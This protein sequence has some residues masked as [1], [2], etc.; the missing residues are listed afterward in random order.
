[1]SAQP[2]AAQDLLRALLPE[3]IPAVMEV[4]R[5]IY[6]FPWTAGNFGDSLAAGHHGWV[7][8]RAGVVQAYALT[9]AV[10]DEIH[11]LNFSVAAH[12]QGQGLG[13]WLLAWLCEQARGQGARAMFLEVRPSNLRA[14]DLYQRSGFTKVGL[15]R[16]YYPAEGDSR[17]DALVL[18]RELDR[19][20]PVRGRAA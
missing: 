14:L 16:R 11:L 10:I 18:R 5:A 2:L 4:E 3:D 8:E 12:R 9:M 15:R 13:R 6:P 7:L 20:S 1:M 17:E 19:A